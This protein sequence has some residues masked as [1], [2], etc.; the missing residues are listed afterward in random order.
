MD[1]AGMAQRR[2]Q[3]EIEHALQARKP[4]AQGLA[5]CSMLECDEPISA[6]R[7]AMGA[8][9]CIECAKAQEQEA[10]R[11]SPRAAR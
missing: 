11:W 10:Q 2:Q 8:R 5:V 7:Q 9:L 1:L 6:L 3:E 4:V